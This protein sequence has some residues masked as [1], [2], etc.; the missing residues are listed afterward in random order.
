MLYAYVLCVCCMYA[1]TYE[2]YNV[3]QLTCTTSPEITA[4]ACAFGAQMA[5]GAVKAAIAPSGFPE[6]S[7]GAAPAHVHAMVVTLSNDLQTH[8]FPLHPFSNFR[9]LR[10]GGGSLCVCVYTLR[11]TEFYEWI[12]TWQLRIKVLTVSISDNLP[13]VH[14]NHLKL[15]VLDVEG[16]IHTSLGCR[17]INESIEDTHCLPVIWLIWR[18]DAFFTYLLHCLNRWTNCYSILRCFADFPTIWTFLPD[19]FS[20]RRD[21]FH[22]GSFFHDGRWRT[23]RFSITNG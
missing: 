3:G 5:V 22:D 23:E 2:F 13:T 8:L 6:P 10:S 1:C 11:Y 20:W 19:D 18:K 17:G 14:R 7:T 15:Y 4:Q 9:I 21:R 16:Y 12:K